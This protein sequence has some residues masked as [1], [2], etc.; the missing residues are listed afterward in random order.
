MQ[1]YVYSALQSE[2]NPKNLTQILIFSLTKYT[3]ISLLLVGYH[4]V[5][6]DTIRS[7]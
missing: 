2:Y 5:K 3:N 4:A 1:M 6:T 7:Y